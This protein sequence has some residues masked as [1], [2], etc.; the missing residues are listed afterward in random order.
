MEP[1]RD[2]HG[3][4]TAGLHAEA[5]RAYEWLVQMQRPDGSWYDYYVGATGGTPEPHR[6]EDAKL[7]TNVCAYVATGVWHHWLITGDRGFV[8]HLW[9]IVQRAIDWVLELQTPRGEIVWAR[10]VDAPAVDLRAAHRLVVDL[11]LA[12]VRAAPGRAGRRGTAPTGSCPASTSADVIRTRPDAFAPKHRWAMDWYYPV[13]SR[14]A[15]RVRQA[16]RRLAGRGAR[17]SWTVSACAA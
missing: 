10:E 8:E 11:P 12:A 16:E 1:R 15:R 4:R 7:D 2:G 3:P 17:S 13:L 5:E 14:R 6:V 9:P